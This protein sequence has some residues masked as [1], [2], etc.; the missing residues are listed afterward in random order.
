MEAT[1]VDAVD[2]ADEDARFLNGQAECQ[3]CNL[4]IAAVQGRSAGLPR[5]ARL[6]AVNR[7][8]RPFIEQ[9][10]QG[11]ARAAD[12]EDITGSMSISATAWPKGLSSGS[13]IF[14]S[15]GVSAFISWIA[16]LLRHACLGDAPKR[17]ISSNMGMANLPRI[18]AETGWSS[19]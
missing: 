2:V 14:C 1:L 7:A 15:S 19:A 18:L 11:L 8:L 6:D 13:F 16:G 5:R 10:I 12:I 9:P 17:S 3:A 4:R